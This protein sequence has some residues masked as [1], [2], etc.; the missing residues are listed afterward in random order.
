VNGSYAAADG[1]QIDTWSDNPGKTT[2]YTHIDALFDDKVINWRLIETHRPDLIRVALSIRAGR[3]SSVALLRRLGH[4][5]HK[6]KLYRAFR[7][8]GRVVRTVVLLR[9]LSEPA[10]RDSIAVITNRMESFN[11]FCQWLSFGSGTLADN[12]P[13]H[14]EKLVKFNELVANCMICSTIPTVPGHLALPPPADEEVPAA[15]APT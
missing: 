1:M 14:Q 2:R 11:G 10:L 13:V 8:F 4:D 12:D 9:Y 5:S 3:I 15:A 6:N 7:E